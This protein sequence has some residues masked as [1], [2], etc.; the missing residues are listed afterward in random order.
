MDEMASEWVESYDIQLAIETAIHPLP[1]EHRF[2]HE[3]A[4]KF[5]PLGR[6]IFKM[7]SH[8]VTAARCL[9]SSRCHSPLAITSP[10]VWAACQQSSKRR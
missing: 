2:A 3:V 10:S 1:N 6:E 4:I 7:I 9:N 8:Y 5:K